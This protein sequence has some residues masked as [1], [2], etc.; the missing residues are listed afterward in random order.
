MKQNDEIFALE[1]R[2]A[3]IILRSNI[4]IK[5]K[6]NFP[7]CLQCVK[8]KIAKTTYLH[9]TNEKKTNVL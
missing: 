4:N 8:V 3:K 7:L 9:K 6:A 2:R 1:R 5:S